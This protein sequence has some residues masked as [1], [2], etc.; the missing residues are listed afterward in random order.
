MADDQVAWA[1]LHG[2]GA[3]ARRAVVA[4]GDAAR[5]L[6]HHRIGTEHLLLGV[7]A[8][9]EGEAARILAD[10]GAGRAAV[11]AKVREVNPPDAAGPLDPQAATPRAA[12]ALGRSERFARRRHG[13]QVA[14]ED[15]VTGVL[16]VEGT[17]G[18][19][20]RSLGVDVDAVRAALDGDAGASPQ[21]GGERRGGDQ[22]TPTCPSCAAA[23]SGLAS[24]SLPSR[25]GADVVVHCCPACG[26]VLGTS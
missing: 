20:L 26:A 23:L 25:G 17:A 3:D 6:G 1:E 24:R 19:V 15:L 21:E 9:P 8:D 5:E 14:L 7:L 16:D 12:R 10:A 22:V 4:A 18:Q 13:G 2:F 11:W